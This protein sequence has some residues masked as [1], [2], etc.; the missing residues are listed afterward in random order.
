MSHSAP[1]LKRPLLRVLDPLLA[2][3]TA[4]ISPLVWAVCRAGKNTPLSR[5]VLDRAG[6]AVVRRHYYEPVVNAADIRKPLELER[7]LPG[8]DLNEAA[9]LDLVKKFR[10]ADELKAIP[11]AKPAVD[12]FGYENTTYAEGDAEMLFNMIRTFK[13]KR[14]IEVG[15]GQ[16][17]LMA[18]LAIEANR[19]EDAGYQCRL[20]CIEPFEQPWLEALGVEVVRQRIEDCPDE[21]VTSLEDGDFFFI[22]SSHVIRPQGDVLH[23][24]LHLL[25]QV[26]NGVFVHVHD[27]FVPRDYPKKWVVDDRRLWNEQYLLEAFLS[28]NSAFEVVLAVNWLTNAHGEKLGEA[29]PMLARKPGKQPGAFWIRRRAA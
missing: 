9:Q 17:T 10:F 27:V 21:I 5:A 12:E 26:A 24:Y 25:P 1:S 29:C 13:P 20:T 6:L 23:L 15:S 8:V 16:S 14:I 3:M 4:I 11:T 2:G 7:P 19:R 22:D 28:F 18:L